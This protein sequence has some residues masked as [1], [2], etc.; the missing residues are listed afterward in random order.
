MY[1]YIL[2]I[3]DIFNDILYLIVRFKLFTVA[4]CTSTYYQQCKTA[5]HFVQT[6]KLCDNEY[7]IDLSI[8]NHVI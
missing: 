5:T 7:L 6:T 3:I 1:A 2:L 8:N 4:C